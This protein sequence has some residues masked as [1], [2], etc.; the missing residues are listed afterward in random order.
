MFDRSIRSVIM[1][2]TS[3]PNTKTDKGI[4][5]TNRKVEQ[6]KPGRRKMSVDPLRIEQRRR[7]IFDTIA[8]I[9]ASRRT[10]TFTLEEIAS[11]MGGSRELIYYYFKS[12]SDIL[13]Q[14][15]M[16]FFDLT[17]EALKPIIEEKNLTRIQL[18]EKLIRGIFLVNCEHHEL[19]RALWGD[20][21]ARHVPVSKASSI[22]R[23]RRKQEDA[24]AGLVESVLQEKGIDG[25]VDARTISR[26]IMGAIASATRWYTP[27][28]KY[29]ASVLAD[30]L[31]NSV[32]NNGFMVHSK[33]YPMNGI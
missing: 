12:K 14:L 32:L 17:D 7:T 5:R 27:R 9:M 30:Y 23:R 4:S 13:Y 29:S 20:M 19:A 25:A 22:I 11:R 8:H 2:R 18:L 10:G 26:F 15:E 24:F 28:G 16:Y 33:T 1:M 3:S 6:G 21:P 31:V